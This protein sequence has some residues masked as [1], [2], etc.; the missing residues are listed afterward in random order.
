M[1]SKN[2]LTLSKHIKDRKPEFIAA[3]FDIDGT[4]TKLENDNIPVPLAQKLASLSKK[5]PLAF[6]TGRD[7][8]HAEKKLKKQIL[9]YAKDKKSA[10]KNWHMICENGALGYFFD[11]KS[12]KYK[13]FYKIK[14]N[15]RLLNRKKL[16]KEIQKALGKLL[17][18]VDET[19]ET[20]FLIRPCK[21]D[22]KTQKDRLKRVKTSA[23]ICEK[24]LS[25]FKNGYK[26]ETLESGLAIHI[27]PKNANKDQGIIK[28][29]KYLKEKYELNAGKSARKILVIGDQPGKGKNDDA[30]LN[31]KYGTPFTVGETTGKKW[32][33]PVV[34]DSRHI[35]KGPIGTL[36]LLKK[37]CK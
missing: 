35:L 5:M 9:I 2:R 20:Q 10:C 19:R 21:K 15:P 18:S 23:K 16:K 12:Q 34:N 32:P 36:F 4:L 24:V 37:I 25:K 33:L 17:E 29:A 11:E 6:A 8:R 26:F 13:E 28:F 14:W 3:M 22:L 1:N 31:G 30:F 7:I 27:S